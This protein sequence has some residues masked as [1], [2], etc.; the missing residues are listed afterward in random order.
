MLDLMNIDDVINWVDRTCIELGV[1][2]SDINSDFFECGGSSL[3]AIK[4][5]SKVDKEMGLNILNPSSLY[6]MP[7]KIGIANQIYN[8]IKEEIN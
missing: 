6:E 2:L 1:I 7:T 4:L 5:I 3:T 8:N